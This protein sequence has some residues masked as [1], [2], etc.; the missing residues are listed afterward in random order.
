MTRLMKIKSNYLRSFVLNNVSIIVPLAP[1]EVQHKALLDDLKRTNAEIILSSEPSRAKSLNAGEKKAK[2]NILWFLHADSRVSKDN[3]QA[4]NKA[5]ATTP[6][7]VHYFDLNFEQRGMIKLN[8][9]G[10]NMRSYLFN[11]PYGD[12]GFCISKKSFDLIGG[13]PENTTYGEDVIFI[14]TAKKEGIAI[15]PVGSKIITSARKYKAQGWLKT[16][17]AHQYCLFN[18]LR[19]KI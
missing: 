4:L 14:R 13:Y 3:I 19:Q 1:N 12:Q 16:T 6:D 10:A 2:H 15:K 11:L 7:A 18:L 5:I 8:A 17:L 9:L